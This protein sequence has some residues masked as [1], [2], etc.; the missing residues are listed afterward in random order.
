MYLK[1]IK[2]N[3]FKSFADKVNI[4]L[5]DNI[6]CIVGPNGSGKSN[7]VDAVR[8][9]LGE[10]SV[11]SLRGTN[12]MSDI[13]FA[14][15]K[16]RNGAS[17]AEVSLTF[18]NSDHYLNS[19]LE[20][21]EVKRVLYK[22][23][24]SDY[25][26]N[27]SRVRLKDITDLFL[28]SGAGNDS[29]NII[30]QGKIEAVVNSKP[31]DRRVIFEEAA[32]VLKY[33]K[34]KDESLKKLEKTK[35]NIDKVNLIIEELQVNLAP[36][37]EQSENAQKYLAYKDEL[38]NNEIALI[39][40]DITT[41][42]QEYTKIKADIDE[43]KENIVNIDT[44]SADEAAKLET[45]KLK[46]IKLDEAINSAN[47]K[48]LEITSK[49]VNLQN[50]KLMYT[51]RK[52]FENNTLNVEDNIVKLKEAILEF[53]K[54][55]NILDNEMTHLTSDLKKYGHDLAEINEEQ[56]FLKIKKNFANNK[57]QTD[58]KEIYGLKN[59]REILENNINN[60]SRMPSAV[61]NIINNLR[62]KG[63][64][65]TIG[66]L[67]EVPKEYITAID[68]ALASSSNFIVVDSDKVAKECI[69]YLKENKLG[70]ATFFPLNIIKE[71]FILKDVLEKL[72]NTAGFIGIASNLV[73]YEEK[74]SN[75]IKNQLGNVVVVDNIDTMNKV[76]KLLDY[77][78][79][80]V[81]LDGEIMHTGGSL[82]GGTSKYENSS[83]K[84]KAEL[85][86]INIDIELKEKSNL[87]LQDEIASLDNDLKVLN[88][89][90]EEINRSIINLKEKINE[91]NNLINSKR[92]KQLELNKELEGSLALQS[93]S[94]DNK[95]LALLDEV[96]EAENEKN[97]TESNLN[98]LKEERS[99]LTSE[100]E[101]L[102]HI[103]REKNSNYN[104]LQNDLKNKEV[105][106]GKMDIRL[107][108]LL[109]SLNE[110]YNLTYEFAKLNYTLEVDSDVARTKVN[111]LKNNIAKLGEVNIFAIEEYERVSTRYNFLTNQKEDLEKAS[112]NLENVINEMDSIMIDKFSTTFNK[113]N[114][115]FKSVFRK[116]FKGGNGMLK[117]TDPDNILETGVEI[118]AEPPGKKLNSIGLLSGGEK[119][120]TALSLL[121]AILNVK[122]VPFCIL[123]EVEAALDEA[124]VDAFGKYLQDKKENSQFIL[125]THKKRTMEYADTLYGITMQESGVSK[126]VSVKLEN[127][128]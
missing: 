78:Y 86:K 105:A 119:T 82:T 66:K 80:I 54:A 109:L 121:F 50:E 47:N 87:K 41:I 52:K 98:K 53:D 25:F 21:I 91:K 106:L 22:N 20:E 45:L 110:N 88:E 39:T 46:S 69:A 27:N 6:T 16:T 120:L 51:E 15:S 114:E 56:S 57:Y 3:G 104:K 122:T 42:N 49:F 90:E 85:E 124:N 2:A 116:L 43:I 111:E 74:F 24:E 61:K 123:D 103:Y 94:V 55:I 79:R 23:G 12:A 72:E 60:D 97:I 62:F 76:G 92:Q 112:V 10:Q 59:R 127:I 65:N 38:K 83:L 11:K 33:K 63:V 29:F 84:D 44:A 7:I 37:K 9:V 34:R 5:Q 101:E 113:I 118:I 4:E 125:I 40:Q 75:I 28:D 117:L 89:K 19:D 13:I 26:I 31:M 99:T 107:D 14:G 102:E 71:K 115:E 67:I 58:L 68:V 32:S 100:I 108:N 36:L 48:L 18:S 77:K 95:L 96:N 64:Y 8:W 35:E 70:R 81:T 1:S 30:S 128:E 93:G 126:L 17:R 73:S